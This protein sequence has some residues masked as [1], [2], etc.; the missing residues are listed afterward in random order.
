MIRRSTSFTENWLGDFQV[1]KEAEELCI[2]TV[3]MIGI[4]LPV[5]WLSDL[6]ETRINCTKRFAKLTGHACFPTCGTVVLSTNPNPVK[7]PT[8][9]SNT[10]FMVTLPIRLNFP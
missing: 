9:K 10:V 6:G 3:T 1:T 5:R 2:G 7:L 8:A 4:Y